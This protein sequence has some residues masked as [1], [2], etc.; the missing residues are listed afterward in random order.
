MTEERECILAGASPRE[1][2][3][4][5]STENVPKLLGRGFGGRKFREFSSVASNFPL[6][7]WRRAPPPPEVGMVQVILSRSF[8]FKRVSEGLH[9]LRTLDTAEAKGR[10]SGPR[11]PSTSTAWAL[12][13]CSS[14]ALPGRARLPRPP[15]P[16]PE[17]R[18]VLLRPVTLLG[19]VLPGDAEESLA[20]V[21]PAQPRV[22]PAL[23][24]RHQPV[25]EAQG[26]PG[27]RRRSPVVGDLPFLP[28]PGVAGHWGRRAP[29]AR[30]RGVR[31]IGPQRNRRSRGHLSGA[32]R[33]RKRK[34]GQAGFTFRFVPSPGRPLPFA[35]PRTAWPKGVGQP[36]GTSWSCGGPPRPTEG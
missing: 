19:C 10:A 1:G 31:S 27:P 21:L 28:P 24:L 30:S 35:P 29:G 7:R 4:L 8:R 22:A 25:A 16:Y 18:R 5:G 13:P 12:G 6:R 34:S 3:V 11:S 33:R 9:L 17:E 14:R 26:T 36:A 2:L 23:D 32:W 15:P 20:L